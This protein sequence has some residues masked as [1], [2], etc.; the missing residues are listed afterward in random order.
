M[1]LYLYSVLGFAQL[2]QG[3]DTTLN[4]LE[5]VRQNGFVSIQYK[6]DINTVRQTLAAVS[7]RNGNKKNRIRP[8]HVYDRSFRVSELF[9]CRVCF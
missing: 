5:T 8:D 1:C 7:Q 9:W 3:F 4:C 6:L 2:K